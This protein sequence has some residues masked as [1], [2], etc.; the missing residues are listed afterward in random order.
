[1][2]NWKQGLAAPIAFAV[3]AAMAAEGA[4]P[5]DKPL[6]DNGEVSLTTLDFDAYMERVP[7]ERRAEFRA[8]YEKINPTVDGLWMRRVMA[9]RA[10]AAGLDK[11][12]LVAARVRI[13]EEDVLAETYMADVAKKVKVPDLEPRARE[14]YKAHLKEFTSPELI[15]G[16]HILVSIKSYPREVARQR[17]QEVFERAKKGEDFAKLADQYSDNKSS[18]DI[19][20]MPLASFAAPLPE[21]VAKLKTPGEI[22]PPVETQYGFHVIKLGEK[23]PPRVKPFDEVRED[24]IAMEKQKLIDD[25]KTAVAEA[26]RADPKTTLHL[27]NVKGLK[28]D[29]AAEIAKI[30]P[31]QR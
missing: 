25:R 7:A 22:M 21:A 12:P 11:D 16:Q 10:R 4:R 29:F 26:I 1:M 24:L 8:E 18:L 30:K 9:A 20:G 13:A 14:L 15:T 23:L 19:N 5:G 3:G 6:V 31:N 2:K 28:S 17:A 27:E